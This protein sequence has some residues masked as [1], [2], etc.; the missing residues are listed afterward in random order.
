M[1]FEYEIKEKI[2]TIS[3]KGKNDDFAMELNV[4]SFN[5]NRP[6]YDLRNWK[7]SENLMLKGITMTA[8]ELQTLKD[9]LNEM[10]II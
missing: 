6:K 8:E 10:D 4:I 3:V 1:E 2:A 5:G 9:T 7:R